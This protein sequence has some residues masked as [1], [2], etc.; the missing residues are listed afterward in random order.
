MKGNLLQG[1]A[2]GKMGD[3]VAKVVHGDQVFAKYQPVVFNPNSP[4]QIAVRSVFTHI[5]KVIKE[6]RLLLKA[7]G[8]IM[9]YMLPSGASKN[10]RNF[11]VPYGFRNQQIL[12]A[13]G[14]SM[15]LS[16]GNPTTIIESY[17][18]QI[19]EL[20]ITAL[21]AYLR[22]VGGTFNLPG[23]GYFGSDKLIPE[24]KAYISQF[25]ASG[26]GLVQDVALDP[27]TFTLQDRTTAIGTPKAMGLH[28]TIAE[29][30]EWNYIYNYMNEENIPDLGEPIP[31]EGAQEQTGRVVFLIDNQGGIITGNTG[32]FIA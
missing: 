31:Y 23:A 22:P 14:N 7:L 15:K 1:T 2:R 26:S 20:I 3:I 13:G 24:G 10:I 18:G 21:G 16:E 9:T 6:N 11:V 17:T 4:K 32:L 5:A 25:A 30:G 29:C 19:W 12:D 28:A 27:N 8:F